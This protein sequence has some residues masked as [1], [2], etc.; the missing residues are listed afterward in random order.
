MNQPDR[1]A[2][3]KIVAGIWTLTVPLLLIGA[4][5]SNMDTVERYYAQLAVAGAVSLVA[6]ISIVGAFLE[7]AWPRYGFLLLSWASAAFW[8]SSAHS[9]YEVSRTSEAN[10]GIHVIPAAFG[11][12]NLAL[13]VLLHAARQGKQKANGA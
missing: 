8:I 9:L 4:L 13:A 5:I 2:V 3:L 11:V 1:I 6:M 7:R 12:F 10:E